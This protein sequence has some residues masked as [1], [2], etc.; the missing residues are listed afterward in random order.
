MLVQGHT[1]NV[2]CIDNIGHGSNLA[3]SGS[4]SVQ[5]PLHISRLVLYYGTHD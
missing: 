4:R 2:K 3:V 5:L 1:A